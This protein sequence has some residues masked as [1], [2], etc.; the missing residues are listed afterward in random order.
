MPL[1]PKTKKLIKLL[2][3]YYEAGECKCISLYHVHG[4]WFKPCGRCKVW[5]KIGNTP[6]AE[7]TKLNEILK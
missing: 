3:K 6:E 1:D 7:F 4:E 2:V 5:E